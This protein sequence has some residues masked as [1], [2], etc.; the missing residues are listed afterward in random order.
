MIE[1]G[2]QGHSWGKL[3][4]HDIGLYSPSFSNLYYYVVKMCLLINLLDGIPPML[5]L[6]DLLLV[7]LLPLASLAL[8]TLASFDEAPEFSPPPSES[9]AVSQLLPARFRAAPVLLLRL[10]EVLQ[11]AAAD[12]SRSRLEAAPPLL[13]LSLQLSLPRPA[14]E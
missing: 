7:L 8:V 5:A 2:L 13:Q 6:V 1:G 10:V 4:G 9:P 11:V 14:D 3:P 12:S